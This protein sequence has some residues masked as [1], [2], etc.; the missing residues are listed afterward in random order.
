MSV[1]AVKHSRPSLPV[2]EG[3]FRPR[4]CELVPRG[5]GEGVKDLTRRNRLAAAARW[6]FLHAAWNGAHSRAS[7]G[8]R[9]RSGPTVRSAGLRSG[10][11]RSQATARAR[12]AGGR[13]SGAAQAAS[14]AP[15]RHGC[16]HSRQRRGYRR[17]LCGSQLREHRQGEELIRTGFGHRERPARQA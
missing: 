13:R 3:A 4:L 9:C 5:N 6:H 11:N 14:S 2:E 7:Q 15:R 17:N 12:R 1:G 8:F 16:E 10:A